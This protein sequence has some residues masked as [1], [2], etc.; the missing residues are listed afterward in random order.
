MW[1]FIFKVGS[2]NSSVTLRPKALKYL[3]NERNLLSMRLS[4]YCIDVEIVPEVYETI[5]LFAANRIKIVV[6]H[7]LYGKERSF[8]RSLAHA[9]YSIT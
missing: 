2:G 6:A 3:G 8:Y 9:L 5:R 7:D 1:E 4:G